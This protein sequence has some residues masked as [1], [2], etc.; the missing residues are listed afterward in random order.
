MSAREPAF[1]YAGWSFDGRDV[2]CRYELGA[3]AFTERFTLPDGPGLGTPALSQV[4]RLLF[5]LAGV[6]YYKTAAPPV[7]DLGATPVTPSD[8]ALLRAFYTHGLGEFAY[9]NDLD[10]SGLQFTGGAEPLPA[11]P[12]DGGADRPLVPFGGGI[13]SVVVAETVRARR[14]E[15]ALFVLG[16]YDAIEGVLEV[17]GLPVLRAARRLDPQLLVRDPAFLNGHVP[18]TGIVSLVALAAAVVDGRGPVV[19]SNEHSASEATVAG[20]N[21]QWSK[22]AAFEGLLRASLAESVPGLGYFSLLRA[23]SELWVAQRFALLPAYHPV[24]R[25]CNRAFTVDPARRLGHWCGECDKCCFIDLILAPYLTPGELEAIFGR[26][27]LDRPDLLPR[28]RS[29]LGDGEHDKPFECVGDVDECRTAVTLAA[30]RPDRQKYPVLQEL[31]AFVAGRAPAEESLLRPLGDD[32]VPPEYADA[33][34]VV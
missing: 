14:P 7:V 2:V 9:V 3:R 25:S 5:L 13:D 23:R 28:F 17:A 20:V 24:F 29:L 1:R 6:S 4:A 21:H 18:V 15:T 10:L 11:T 34:V 19:M 31:S 16:S 33:D 32:A 22:S 27:P 30:A 8:R 26:E 12:Y